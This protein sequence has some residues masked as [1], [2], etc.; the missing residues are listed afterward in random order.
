M[1]NPTFKVSS[2]IKSISSTA[3][4]CRAGY[5]AAKQAGTLIVPKS[6]PDVNYVFQ[7]VSKV[8]RFFATAAFLPRI[9]RIITNFRVTFVSIREIRGR[10]KF[11][12]L[13]TNTVFTSFPALILSPLA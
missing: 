11:N 2:V 12:V 13:L 8:K 1:I 3:G 4:E 6:W 10:N 7:G 5:D 9:T